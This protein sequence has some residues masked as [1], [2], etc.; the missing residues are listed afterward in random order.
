M[1]D[2]SNSEQPKTEATA[3]PHPRQVIGWNGSLEDLAAAIATMQYDRFSDFMG[4]LAKEISNQSDADWK[5]GRARLSARLRVVSHDINMVQHGLRAA[6][7]I[8][9]PYMKQ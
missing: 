8:C 5:K 7:G 6:W 2:D 1:T 4:M 9:E 3:T